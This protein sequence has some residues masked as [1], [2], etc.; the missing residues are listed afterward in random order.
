M[1]VKCTLVWAKQDL[2]GLGAVIVYTVASFPFAKML[3]PLGDHFVK[4]EKILKGN[5]NSISSPSASLKIYIMG[6]TLL[7]V[8]NKQ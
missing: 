2:W 6:I 8:V 4:I 5:L 7:G 3:P 1:Y